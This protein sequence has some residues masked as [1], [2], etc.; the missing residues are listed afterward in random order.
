MEQPVVHS[1]R[2]GGR[3]GGRKDERERRSEGRRLAGRL[4]CISIYI[5]CV[6]RAST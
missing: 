5:L 6:C 1:K 3:E 4:R 2:E